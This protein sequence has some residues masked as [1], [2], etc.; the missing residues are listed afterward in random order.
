[1]KFTV[2]TLAGVKGKYGTAD[3]G[4]G[5]SRLHHPA[6]LALGNN[7]LFVA[8]YDNHAIRAI[9]L[10]PVTDPAVAAEVAAMEPEWNRTDYLRTQFTHKQ[11]ASL[12]AAMTD[13]DRRKVIREMPW[14]FR[15]D[16]IDPLT[17]AVQSERCCA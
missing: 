8:D 11:R 13:A 12:I 1:M 5:T 3:G 6:A 14:W 16:L 4:Q 7:V 17:V 10:G 15:R 2:T 9:T